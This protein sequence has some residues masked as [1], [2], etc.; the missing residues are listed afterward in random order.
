MIDRPLS[1]AGGDRGI[2]ELQLPGGANLG[3]GSI[4]TTPPFGRKR[5]INS[6]GLKVGLELGKF[7]NSDRRSTFNPALRL[8]GC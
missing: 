3:Q 4:T 6:S 5:T 8:G 2:S 1:R 7:D